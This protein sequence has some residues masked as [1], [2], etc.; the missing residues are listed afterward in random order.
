MKNINLILLITLSIIIYSCSAPKKGI[1]WPEDR[2]K[3]PV[4]HEAKP[5]QKAVEPKKEES[6]PAKKYL[7]RMGYVVQVGAFSNM[8]NAVRLTDILENRGYDAYHIRAKV[9]GRWFYRVRFGDYQTYAQA[10][11]N[12]DAIVEAG[13]VDS[14]FIAP[15]NKVDFTRLGIRDQKKLRLALVRT[16]KEYLGVRYKWGGISRRTGFDC[17]GL[18][19][20]TYRLNGLNLPRNSRAQFDAGDTVSKSRMQPG[21]LVFFA[22]GRNRKRVSHVGMYIGGGKFVHAPNKRKRIKIENMNGRYY[23]SRFLGAKTYL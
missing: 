5:E 3:P 16:V 2:P 4:K 8:D 18:M 17:S 15:P 9:N 23:R 12:G 11:R 1:D 6:K 20:V 19:M 13:L 22:T 10:K 7:K 14:Y 21:D